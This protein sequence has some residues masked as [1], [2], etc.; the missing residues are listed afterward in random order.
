MGYEWEIN[1]VQHQT[2]GGTPRIK[3]MRNPAAIIDR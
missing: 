3:Q 2:E 1:V